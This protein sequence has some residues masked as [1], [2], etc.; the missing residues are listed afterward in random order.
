[1]PG[2]YSVFEEPPTEPSFGLDTA[3]SDTSTDLKF[4]KDLTWAD[5]RSG[6][7]ALH[8][9]LKALSATL[10]Y[11]NRGANRWTETWADSAA[12]MARIT[13]QRPVRML[14]HAD[15]LINLAPAR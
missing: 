12:A 10:P 7:Q 9:Q 4:W 5:A 13:L 8:V 6:K 3:A 15:Q 14:V 11:D 1:M 2:W